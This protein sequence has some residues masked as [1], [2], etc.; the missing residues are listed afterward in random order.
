MT[1][2]MWNHASSVGVRILDQQHGVLMDTLN[3][4][5]VGIASGAPANEVQE[6]IERLVEY[7]RRHFQSEQ[8]LMEQYA[9]P[10]RM[11]HEAEHQ[12]LL[13][14]IV[15]AARAMQLGEPVHLRTMTGFIR[16]WFSTHMDGI[17]HELG[18]WLNQQGVE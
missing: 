4:L 17:D 3:Q 14:Q 18:D 2:L 6:L 11:A 13:A 5:S 15:D 12:K 1:L 7:T 9:Y 8:A 10:G 16:Q